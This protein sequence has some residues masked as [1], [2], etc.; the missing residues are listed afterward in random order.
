MQSD[1][2]MLAL[3][4]NV[5]KKCGHRLPQKISLQLVRPGSALAAPKGSHRSVASPRQMKQI[6]REEELALGNLSPR[7]STPRFGKEGLMTDGNEASSNDARTSKLIARL[8]TMQTKQMQ[9]AALGTTVALHLRS[10][11]AGM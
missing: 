9:A 6:W 7:A 2:L 3:L 5:D 10:S 1:D 4:S 8:S 11:M